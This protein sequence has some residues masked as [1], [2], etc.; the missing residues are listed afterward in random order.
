MKVL[1]QKKFVYITDE[2]GKKYLYKF[3]ELN[4]YEQLTILD[5]SKE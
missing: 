2:L 5:D 3:L 4:K 1:L